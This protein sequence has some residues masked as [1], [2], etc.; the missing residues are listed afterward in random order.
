MRRKEPHL[1]W[2]L[3][4]VA[5]SALV[6]LLF[7][8]NYRVNLAKLNIETGF[9]FLEDTAGFAIS[10]KLISYDESSSY[11]RAY[12]VGLLNTLLVTVLAVT[13]A[14][15]LGLLIA[16]ARLSKNNWLLQKLAYGYTE[17]FRNIPPLLHVLFWYQVFFLRILPKEALVFFRHIYLNIRGL[18]VPAWQWKPFG[19]WLFLAVLVFLVLGFWLLGRY[20]RNQRRLGQFRNYWPWQLG[21]LATACIAFFAAQPYT[22]LYPETGR[23]GFTQGFTVTPELISIVVALSSYSA[24]YISE[25]IRSSV[26]AVPKGQ[27]EAARSLGLKRSLYMRLII[28]PQALRTVIPPVISQYLNI[29]KNS[30]LGVVIA[31]PDLVSVFSGS[32]LNQVGRALEIIFMTMLT[33][34]MISI[35]ISFI[36]NRYNKYLLSRGG[37]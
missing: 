37:V 25:A 22:L 12:Q 16:L 5:L 20:R 26:E 11:F 13:L 23:F 31:Y 15:V 32:T 4:V 35:A 36:M 9:G 14:T 17:M 10:P 7:I 28:L 21:I 2:Q 33:Y 24:V 19:I 29:L 27:S 18:T 3:L 8:G 6:L 1:F 34:L 30:S